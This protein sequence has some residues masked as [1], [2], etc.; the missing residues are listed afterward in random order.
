MNRERLCFSAAGLL[1]A[2]ALLAGYR[3][4]VVL[5]IVFVLLTSGALALGGKPPR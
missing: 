4:D 3:G 5:G 2:G 1:T